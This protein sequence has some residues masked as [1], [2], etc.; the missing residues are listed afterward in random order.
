MCLQAESVNQ[1]T[2]ISDFLKILKKNCKKEQKKSSISSI[3]SSC[4]KKLEFYLK[5]LILVPIRFH[6]S[7]SFRSVPH[8]NMLLNSRSNN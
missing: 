6:T 2:M 4:Q 7:S 3:F 8:A 5:S 1:R